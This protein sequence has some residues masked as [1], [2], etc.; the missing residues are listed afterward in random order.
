MFLHVVHIYRQT[1]PNLC[2]KQ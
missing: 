1:N 2:K